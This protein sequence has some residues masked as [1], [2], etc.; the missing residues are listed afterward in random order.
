MQQLGPLSARRCA[1][2][3]VQQAAGIRCHHDI[4]RH[5]GA[6]FRVYKHDLFKI[7]V[8]HIYFDA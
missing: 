1:A 2:L 8:R 4:R 6:G 5:E 7:K 3:H